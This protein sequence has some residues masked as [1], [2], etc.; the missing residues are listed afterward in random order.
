MRY[1]AQEKTHNMHECT[2][3]VGTLN[4]RKQHSAAA[5]A[6]YR[7]IK[8]ARTTHRWQA[9][10]HAVAMSYTCSVRDARD[11]LIQDK[12]GRLCAKRVSRLQVKVEARQREYVGSR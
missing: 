7:L 12:N 9:L 4:E 10:D 3:R 6:P 2:T 11:G 8:C 5:N 1:E